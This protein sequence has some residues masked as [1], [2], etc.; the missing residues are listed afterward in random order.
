MRGLAKQVF[1]DTAD[2]GLQKILDKIE[3]APILVMP[4]DRED[5]QYGGVTQRGE[6]LLRRSALARPFRCILILLHEGQHL[7]EFERRGPAPLV[8]YER[9]VRLLEEEV[10][11]Y[12][13]DAGRARKLLAY[14]EAHLDDL[15]I[16]PD[17]LADLQHAETSSSLYSLE[18]DLKLSALWAAEGW[19]SLE[20][21]SA[22]RNKPDLEKDA[23]TNKGAAWRIGKSRRLGSLEVSYRE[24]EANLSKLRET[25]RENYA[26]GAERDEILGRLDSA[27]LQVENYEVFLKKAN[28]LK[29]N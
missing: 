13:A 29:T 12:R 15:P 21:D 10:E 14:A 22:V 6:I 1:S 8:P 2:E 9:L 28:D 11:A 26:P 20:V 3:H 16:G 4:P 19:F 7:V 25:V 24:L 18:H 23:E 5:M 27:L 17:D